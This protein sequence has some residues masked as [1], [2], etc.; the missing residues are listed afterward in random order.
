M[1]PVAAVAAGQPAGWGL[2]H[3]FDLLKKTNNTVSVM[4]A[5]DAGAREIKGRPP[6]EVGKPV[7]PRVPCSS[8]SP[9]PEQVILPLTSHFYSHGFAWTQV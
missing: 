3:V 8:F 1:V 2:H 7:P 4:E 6:G 5:R 9:E